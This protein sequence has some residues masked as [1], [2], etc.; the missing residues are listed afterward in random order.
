MEAERRRQKRRKVT[1]YLP[2]VD[3]NTLQTIG[4]LTD[5]SAI[6][7]RVDSKKS[8]PVNASYRL[9]LDLTQDMA[10]K[11]FMVFNGRSRWCKMDRLEPNTFNVGFEVGAL[12]RDDIEIF[13]R[14]YDQY[15][16]DSMW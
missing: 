3:A 6:G 7:I 10:N 8:L 9:R 11:S 15:G 4:Y 14:I 2:V 5:I 13:R 16:S 12:S 1:Y